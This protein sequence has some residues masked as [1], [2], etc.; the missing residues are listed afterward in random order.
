MPLPLS[1]RLGDDSVASFSRAAVQRWNDAEV[2][3]RAKRRLAA[4]YFLGYSTEMLLKAAY[5]RSLGFASGRAIF[6]SDRDQ[7]RGEYARLGLV[8]KPGQHD[9][10][11]W[12]QL[13]VA[14]RYDLGTPHAAGVD[15]QIVNQAQTIYDH[16]LETIRYHSTRVYR[17]EIESVRDAVLWFHKNERIL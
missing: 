10:T 8:Q 17:Q 5:F 11:G 1:Q 3:R 4:I 14:K 12:A 9:L 16:W 15:R 2:L 6:P 13:L 7:A